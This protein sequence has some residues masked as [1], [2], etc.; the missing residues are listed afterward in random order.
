MSS[1]PARVQSRVSFD[2][3][4]AL[5]SYVTGDFSPSSEVDELREVVLLY[6]LE[7]R[8][9]IALCYRGERL[10]SADGT[11]RP[12]TCDN[13]FAC[14]ICSPYRLDQ[15]LDKIK[16]ILHAHP[17]VVSL[18]LSAQHRGPLARSLDDLQ[19]IWTS[20]YTTGSWMTDFRKRT[21]MVGWV[22]STEVTFP[23]TGAHPHIHALMVFDRIP[24]QADVDDLRGQWIGRASK[25]GF[26]TSL[27]A[28]EAQIVPPG[29]DRDKLARYLTKQNAMHK[30]SEG[31]AR[32]P[33]D[34]LVSVRRTGDAEDLA[35][36]LDFQL[37][38]KGRHKIST[39]R[40]FWGL[41]SPGARASPK[42][43]QETSPD[44]G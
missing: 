36:L 5:S 20:A 9:S 21:G 11:T 32:T 31:M 17:G 13:K 1:V 12:R 25:L 27:S 23:E 16:P 7:D 39:S 37:A 33:G 35:R 15:D 8:P 4:A 19:R 38:T 30:S 22:R 2:E 40:G 6:S 14:P 26:S 29:P 41:L 43:N 18:T 24:T 34:L 28:L 42:R 44:V 10:V 3:R